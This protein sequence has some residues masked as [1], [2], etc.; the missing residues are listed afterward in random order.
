MDYVLSEQHHGAD[1]SLSADTVGDAAAFTPW[2]CVSCFSAAAK[3]FFGWVRRL[4][5]LARVWRVFCLFLRVR[6]RDY[7]VDMPALAQA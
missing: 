3:P 4:A 1:L 2:V 7:Y 5:D 6:F